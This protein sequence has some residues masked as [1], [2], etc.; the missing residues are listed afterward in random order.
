[1]A[2]GSL[3]LLH[4]FWRRLP[5]ERRRAVLARV[6][7][8]VAP[9]PDRRPPAAVGGIAVVG[10]LSRASGLGEAARLMRL[11]L[12]GLG[13]AT[14]SLDIG[15][16]LPGGSA[17]AAPRMD[18]PPAGAPLLIH[19]NAPSLPWVLLGLPRA[20]LRGRRVIAYWAW[21]LPVAPDPWR[22]ALPF[23]HEVWVLSRFTGDALAGLLPRDGRIPLRVVPIPVA[24]S[25]PV[26]SRLR[27]ADFGLPD[28]AVVVLTSFSLASSFARKNPLGAITAFVRA[29]GDRADR[30]LVLKVGHAEHFPADLAMLREAVGGAANIR[31]ETRIFPTA[32]SHALTACADIV[33]S[34]HRAEGFGLVPAEAMLLG[35]PVVATGWSGNMEFMDADSAALVD[36]SLIPAVDPRGVFQAPGALWA[37]PDIEHASAQL[38]RLADD[39]GARAALGTAG[40][41]MARRRLGDQAVRDAVRGLGLAAS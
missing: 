21:E 32:D 41:A 17:E 30:V 14:W 12:T 36:F 29:F 35:V 18:V 25:P 19:V 40:Q 6:T 20:L 11:A 3:S 28:D 31:L 13:V 7:A 2:D 5:V 23:V 33:L 24:M 26:P 34:V 9:R 4:R 8:W 22:L 15:A 16:R 1:M 39:P 37:E 27:R 10:E 38:R